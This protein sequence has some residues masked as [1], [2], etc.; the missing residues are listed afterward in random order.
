[1]TAEPARERHCA[2]FHDPLAALPPARKYLDLGLVAVTLRDWSNTT[3]AMDWALAR[4]DAER[5]AQLLS[6][7]YL[8]WLGADALPAEEGYRRCHTVLESELS[9][10]TRAFTTVIASA[11]AWATGQRDEAVDLAEAAVTVARGVDDPGL[12]GAAASHG[13]EVPLGHR[14]GPVAGAVRV[15]DRRRRCFR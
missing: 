2:A 9:P 8:V 15:G 13:G 10:A 5:A 1:M 12:L 14:P 7:T 11:A 6:G 4:G 3:V